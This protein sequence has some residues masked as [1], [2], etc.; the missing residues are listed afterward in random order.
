MNYRYNFLQK[1][2]NFIK[3]ILTQTPQ[4]LSAYLQSS[5]EI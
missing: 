3:K 1:F 2:L 5:L 4:G